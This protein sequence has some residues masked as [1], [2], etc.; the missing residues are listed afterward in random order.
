MLYCIIAVLLAVIVALLICNEKAIRK[1]IV[2]LAG[3]IVALLV[4]LH[5]LHDVTFTGPV[6]AVAVALVAGVACGVYT[7]NAIFRK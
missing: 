6:F 5:Y 2:G 3:T 4:F 7:V 1:V